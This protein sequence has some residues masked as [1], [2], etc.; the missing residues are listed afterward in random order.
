MTQGPWVGQPGARAESAE[1]SPS[2]TEDEETSKA[3]YLDVDAENFGTTPSNARE[4]E[5]E[6]PWDG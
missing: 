6:L 5:A 4:G 2:R 3:S 1:R